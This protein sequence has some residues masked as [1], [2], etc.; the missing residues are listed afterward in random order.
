M[1]MVSVTWR[2]A[3]RARLVRPDLGDEDVKPHPATHPT[4]GIYVVMILIGLF[5]PIVAVFGY[6]AIAIFILV[7][8]SAMRH[9]NGDR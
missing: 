4:L 5:V 6:L 9:R 1:V 8:S 3:V 2:Y 7:P